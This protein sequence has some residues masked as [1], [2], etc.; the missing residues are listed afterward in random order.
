MPNWKDGGSAGGG[1]GQG[2]VIDGMGFG[3]RRKVG[4]SM[5]GGGGCGLMITCNFEGPIENNV[6]A[7]E[8]ER[9]SSRRRDIQKHS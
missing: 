6:C 8:A 1:G 2:G 9:C 5:V 7:L 4:G 3:V